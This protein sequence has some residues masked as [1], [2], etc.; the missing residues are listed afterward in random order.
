M[1]LPRTHQ[2]SLTPHEL[3][4]VAEEETI[5]IVPLISMDRLRLLSV[6][7][8]SLPF[9]RVLAPLSLA[10]LTELLIWDLPSSSLGHVGYL[11]TLQASDTNQGAALDGRQ[12]QGEAKVSH[13]PARLVGSRQV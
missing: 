10:D 5:D 3:E 12:P 4:Y 9:R 8:C 2:A 11:R 7:Q 6:R 1:A 13:R